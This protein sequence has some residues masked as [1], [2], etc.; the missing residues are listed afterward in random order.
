MDGRNRLIDRA[1]GHTRAGVA[2][3]KPGRGVNP[4]LP[5]QSIGR[6]IDRRLHVPRWSAD[7]R[8][9]FIA[10]PL[11]AALPLA[12]DAM[13]ST[14]LGLEEGASVASLSNLRI[15][16]EIQPRSRRSGRAPRPV[17][18]VGR[19]K[20][21]VRPSI[22][23]AG[24]KCAASKH[25]RSRTVPRPSS[26]EAEWPG[27]ATRQRC[28]YGRSKVAARPWTWRRGRPIWVRLRR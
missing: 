23:Q 12:A 6:S 18:M 10:F 19:W 8:G 11:A 4:S 5:N 27:E 20:R 14:V 1:G 3:S 17:G 15:G 21:G 7:S 28:S 25:T 9:V 26:V 22:G 16:L 24:R 2:T 13:G